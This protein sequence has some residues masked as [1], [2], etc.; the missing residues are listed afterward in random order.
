MDET[1]VP[2]PETEPAVDLTGELVEMAGRVDYLERFIAALVGKVGPIQVRG[3]EFVAARPTDLRPMHTGNPATAAQD[4]APILWVLPE[5]VGPDGLRTREDAVAT[6]LAS[7]QDADLKEQA[8][9]VLREL[10]LPV[11][12]VD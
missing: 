8:R 3:S 9:A 4:D 6:V 1:P 10:G 12:E 2:E 7:W 11:R 5:Y